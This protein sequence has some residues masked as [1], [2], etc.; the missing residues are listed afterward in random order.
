MCEWGVVDSCS[1]VVITTREDDGKLKDG[2]SVA[3]C[4]D[5]EVA[6]H[7]VRLHNEWD[8]RR[9]ELKEQEKLK[10]IEWT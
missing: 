6:R 10:H 4:H 1:R 5:I 2:E 8:K 9:E 3:I 7:I